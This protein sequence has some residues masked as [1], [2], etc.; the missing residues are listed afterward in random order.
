MLLIVSCS[1]DVILPVL[2]ILLIPTISD[3]ESTKIAFSAV[4]WPSVIPDNLLRSVAVASTN[5]EPI[6][7]LRQHHYEII[8]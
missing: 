7:V 1:C 6:E 8:L 4:T 5:V 3:E 2:V